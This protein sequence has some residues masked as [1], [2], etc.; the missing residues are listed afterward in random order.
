MRMHSRLLCRLRIKL[1]ITMADL[2]AHLSGRH[3]G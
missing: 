3:P 2:T 1:V